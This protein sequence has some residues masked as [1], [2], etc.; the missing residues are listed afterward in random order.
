MGGGGLEGLGGLK[1]LK[2]PFERD[3]ELFPFVLLLSPDTATSGSSDP[4]VLTLARRAEGREQ[5]N[6][7]NIPSL[8]KNSRKVKA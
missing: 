3:G 6:K 7:T 5:G 1:G 8:F 4:F 2:P